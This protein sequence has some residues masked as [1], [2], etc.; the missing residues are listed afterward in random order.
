VDLS[1]IVPV[2]ARYEVRNVQD[3]YG[4]PVASGSF[5]GG[6]VSIPLGGVTPPTPV[7]LT[8]SRS[9]RTGPYFDV[10]LVTIL[11]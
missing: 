6:A 2:G 3:L 11:P 7:G 10:F 5:G 1:G 9:P 8:S 4:A